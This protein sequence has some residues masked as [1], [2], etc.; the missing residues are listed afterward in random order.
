[1][2]TL[3]GG[4]SFGL[5]ICRQ[6]RAER[7]AEKPQQL[8]EVVPAQLESATS[9]A[10]RAA[11]LVA[12]GGA[13]ARRAVAASYRCLGSLSIFTLPCWCPV[14]F[15][16]VLCTVI[17]QVCCRTECCAPWRDCFDWREFPEPVR[18]CRSRVAELDPND[19]ENW[20]AL[21]SHCQ[22]ATVHGQELSAAECFSRSNRA[23]HTAGKWYAL[24]ELGG[25]SA[26][27]REYTAKE[28]FERALEA[29]L[30]IGHFGMRAWH[31]LGVQGGGS[32]HGQ[33]YT[34]TECH[35]RALELGYNERWTSMD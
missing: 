17:F 32:V 25:G 16:G 26:G 13:P 19:S 27:G 30:A 23:P 20:I 9:A 28:C 5:N 35:A 22:G 8:A 4:R 6:V 1:M 33:A 15:V 3:R 7:I 2:R 21:G 31:E 24:G 14:W 29:E 10:W 18:W 12:A 34:A 11:D